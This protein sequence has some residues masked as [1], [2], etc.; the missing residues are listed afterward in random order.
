MKKFLLTT[1]VIFLIILQSIG[2]QVNNSF[3]DAVADWSLS[4]VNDMTI[5]NS[6]LKIHGDVKFVQLTAGEARDSKIRGG[7]GIAAK[8]NGGWLDAGQGANNELDVSGYNLSIL[9][10]VKPGEVNAFTPLVDK[11]GNDQSIAYC[12]ALTKKG[13]DVYIESLVGS[14]DIG[15]AYFLKYKLPAAEVNRWHDII[16]RFNGKI[17]QL[18]V[19]GYLRDDEVTVGEIR[20]W[21]RRPLLIGAEYKNQYGYVD[22]NA[23]Q[24]EASFTGLIDHVAIWNHYL[25]DN[26]VKVMSGVNE[27]KDGRPEYY[28]EKYRPQFHFSAKKYWLND[29]NGLVYFNGIYHL[30]YQYMPP[31]RPGAYKDWGQAISRDLVHWEQVPYHLTPQKVWGGCWTGSA[32]VDINNSA[33]FQ[34]GKSKTIVAIVTLGGEPKSGLGPLCTQDIAYSNDGGKTFDYYDQ[35]PVIKN[36]NGYNRDPKVVWDSTSGKWILS[37]YMDK[38]N[39]FDLFSSSNLKSWKYLSGVNLQGV[40][41]CPGFMP[42]PVDGNKSDIKWLFYGANGHYVIGSFDGTNFT[43]ETGVLRL[44]YGMN[45]YAAQT[46]NNA[47]G[48]RCILI[49]WMPTQQYP[50]M[51]FQQQMTFPTELTLHNTPDGL[52]AYRMPVP[53]IKTLYDKKYEWTDKTLK[54]GENIFN[55]LNGQL[56]DMNIEVDVK[57]SASFTIG[58][59]NIAIH[60]NTLTGI[61]SCGGD[62]MK[63]NPERNSSKLNKIDNMGQALLKSVNGKIKLRILLDRT[64]VE[65]FGNDGVV[66]MSSCFMPKD[67]DSNYFF[68]ANGEVKI[69]NA[70]VH[71]LKSAWLSS[72]NIVNVK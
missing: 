65:I 70:V 41:E 56:F 45:Y 23:S 55:K 50:G 35:N 63:I 27:L 61:L 40:S 64:S 49:A 44:D 38:E 60:Y 30:Y 5:P 9:V 6:Q 3:K 54:P 58:L 18:Y 22:G 34:T 46:W 14:D 26:E 12:L 29:P 62:E 71:T 69:E 48:G 31:H 8:F 24:V 2:Q 72:A 7:D 53:E 4:N 67:D 21:N 32:V 10:R 57:D 68:S 16:L 43:R 36:I 47:P 42:L 37:L 33:G 1:S 59:R 17:S 28:K 51:P 19:D 52:K 25:T 20:D 13:N 66:V 39:E 15:G 11:A